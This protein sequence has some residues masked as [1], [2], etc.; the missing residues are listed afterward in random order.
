MKVVEALHRAL[1][2]TRGA[3]VAVA[4]VDTVSRRIRFSGLGN[5]AG[6]TIGSGRPQSLLSHNGTAGHHSSRIQEFEY[7]LADPALIIL[8]SDGLTTSWTLD[9]YPGLKR[10][11]PAIIAGVLY[12]DASRQ[13]DDACIV[14]TRSQQP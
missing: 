7:P 9:A 6:V 1:K 3:A 13:R 12:R 11:H 4:A 14:V 5:I 10:R 2:P 8:H